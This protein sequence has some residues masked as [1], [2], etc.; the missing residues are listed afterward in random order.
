MFRHRQQSLQQ[1]VEYF[2]V[3]KC[4]GNEQHKVCY[5]VDRHPD[6]PAYAA[7]CLE[8]RQINRYC[9]KDG[10]E[11]ENGS[12]PDNS[13]GLFMIIIAFSVRSPE[14]LQALRCLSAPLGSSPPPPL[15]SLAGVFRSGCL[16]ERRCLVIRDRREAGA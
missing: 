12:V 8:Q 4:H 6:Q 16:G 3:H 15:L 5:K 1:P 7:V 11:D 2:I 9:N 10:N 14:R 13:V